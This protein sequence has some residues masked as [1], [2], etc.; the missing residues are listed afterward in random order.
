M[1]VLAVHSRK[2]TKNRCR[3]STLVSHR[4]SIYSLPFPEIQTVQSRSL[5]AARSTRRARISFPRLTS[6]QKSAPTLPGANPSRRIS[7]SAGGAS[8]INGTIASWRNAKDVPHTGKYHECSDKNSNLNPRKECRFTRGV[9]RVEGTD[10]LS[11]E[12]SAPR[13]TV[14]CSVTPCVQQ[15]HALR[16]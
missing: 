14:F 16:E 11:S 9:P 1:F 3:P 15:L 12:P 7:R 6:T 2:R 8:L 4:Y 10:S 13:V 5:R